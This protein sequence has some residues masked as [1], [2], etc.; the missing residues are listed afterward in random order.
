MADS[1]ITLSGP[2]GTLLFRETAA[3]ATLETNVFGKTGAEIY[4]VKVDATQN[5]GEDVYLCLYDNNSA[6]A[7]NITVG[8]T[9]PFFVLKCGAG[10]VVELVIPCGNTVDGSNYVHAAVKQ[11]AGIAGNTSP[12]GTVAITLLGA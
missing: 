7:A 11:S 9:V 3:T 5:T 6:S 8:T 2:R 12:T 10:K 4:A 1:L